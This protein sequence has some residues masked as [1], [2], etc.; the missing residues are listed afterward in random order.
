M[1]FLNIIP[2]IFCTAFLAAN[3]IFSFDGLPVQYYGN[4]VYGLGMG[5]S[6]TGDLFRINTDYLNP[7]VASTSNQVTFST[8]VSLGY[9]RY[10]DKDSSYRAD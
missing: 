10:K 9:I 2:I 3:S 7:S 5:E 6:G 8:A 4:D 1:K